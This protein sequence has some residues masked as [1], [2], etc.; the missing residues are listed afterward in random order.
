MY[1]PISCCTIFRM[2]LAFRG[3]AAVGFRGSPFFLELG[4]F[5]SCFWLGS[6]LKQALVLGW[7]TKDPVIEAN[8]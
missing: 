8:G 4:G 7:S 3:S 2:R 5:N 6:C 1:F